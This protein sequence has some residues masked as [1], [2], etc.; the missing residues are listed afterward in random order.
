MRVISYNHP[1]TQAEIKNKDILLATDTDG[2][3][4][5]AHPQGLDE[6]KG[7]G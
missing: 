5:K 1:M 7:L 6:G 3:I 4:C 2:I